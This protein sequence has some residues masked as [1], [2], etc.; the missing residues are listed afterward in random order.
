[1][2]KSITVTTATVTKKSGELKSLNSNLK[3]QISSLRT[4]EKALNSMWEGDANN[5][6]HKAFEKDATQMDN[7]YNAIEKYISSLDTIVKTYEKA[8]KTN[9]STANKRKY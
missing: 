9:V 4:A 7:F 6:F 2:A 1:M 3:K 5:A 8:E